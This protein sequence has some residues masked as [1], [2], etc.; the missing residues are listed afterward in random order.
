MN[1]IEVKDLKKHFG[2]TKAVDGISF[3][4][5]QG[6][7]FGFLGPNGAGKTTTIRCLMDFIRPDTGTMSIFSQDAHEHSVKLKKRIGYLPADPQLYDKWTGQ[8]HFSLI[9]SMRGPAPELSRLIKRLDFNPKIKVKNLSTGNKQKLG[10]ILALMTS[11][12]LLILDEPTRGLDPL[13]QNVIYDEL[14]GFSQHRGTVFMSSHILSEVEHVCDRAA[15][16]KQGKLV[17]LE[18]IGELRG[19]KVHR[20]I[21]EF[22]S[23]YQKSDFILPGVEFI[24]EH[25]QGFTAKV[26]GDLSPFLRKLQLYEVKDLEVTHASLEEAFFNLY[27]HE[28]L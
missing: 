23:S 2:Q 11:P 6:E 10:L 7:I 16:I 25:T 22:G 8:E 4:V 26:S 5:R 3:E 27:N 12:E 24:S 19:K 1:A 15:I 18:E 20:I 14:R 21:V 17:A 13:L 9:T 28:G